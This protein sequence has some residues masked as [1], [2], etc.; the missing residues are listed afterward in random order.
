MHKPVKMYNDISNQQDAEKF[1]V[2]IL[3]S[4][5]YMFRATVSPIFRNTLTVYTA[6]W[7]NVPILLSAINQSVAD[8]TVGTLFQKAVYT[9]KVFLKMWETV[10]RNRDSKL[11]RINKTK[12]AASCWLLISLY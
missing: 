7:N 3:L 10:A 11:K 2:L 9:V 8:S 5:L 6:F 4:L 1:V 12:F